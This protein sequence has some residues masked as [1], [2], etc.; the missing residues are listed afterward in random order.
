M[1]LLQLKYFQTVAKFENVTRAA[2]ELNIAQPSLSKTISNLEKDLGVSLFDRPG[3]R[4]RLN[5]FGT[6][7]L[8][9]VQNSFSELEQGQKELMDMAGLEQGNINIG[10]SIARL[11]PK[12]F[13]EFLNHHGNVRFR[14]IQ[15]INHLDLQQRLINGRIDLCISILPV[16]EN[17][18]H[19]TPLFDEEIFLAVMPKHRLA[20]RENINL[21]EIADEP[22]IRY[23]A[24]SALRLITDNLF[25][26]AE[27]IPDTAFECTTPEVICSLVQNGFG[28]A[29]IPAS[30]WNLT[31]MDALVK[32]SIR[33]PVCKRTI[34]LSWMENHYLSQAADK[35]KE[36]VI[37]YYA[38][39]KVNSP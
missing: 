5:K 38:A 16:E 1:D 28:I 24:D 2:E 18:V 27:I 35:F 36:F 9:R 37:D 34:W 7:F 23:A 11:L 10:A 31:G 8:K 30:W 17:K 3:R 12:M 21:K 19:C 25:Q 39:D 33:K 29:L 20:G 6:A 14:L 15:V 26:E 13:S 22:F 32:V 4:I